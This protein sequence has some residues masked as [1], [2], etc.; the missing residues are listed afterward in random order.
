MDV[1]DREFLTGGERAFLSALLD[2]GLRFLVVGM[3]ERPASGARGGW[4]GASTAR[5]Q[6]ER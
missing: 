3:S 6:Q 4:L 1:D 2:L 5:R